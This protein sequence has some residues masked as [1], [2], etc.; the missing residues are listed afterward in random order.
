MRANG[1]LGNGLKVLGTEDGVA[2]V[3]LPSGRT[4]RGKTGG[5]D[6]RGAFEAPPPP[7]MPR[8]PE[9]ARVYR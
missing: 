2:T 9:V 4:I 8:V 1:G 3:R 6:E 7:Y 5:W